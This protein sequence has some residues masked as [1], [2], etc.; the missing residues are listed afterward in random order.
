MNWK[1]YGSYLVL[2]SNAGLIPQF[3]GGTEEDREKSESVLPPRISLS[4]CRK[5]LKYYLNLPTTTSFHILS[6]S[7]SSK[8]SCR[9]IYI[10]YMLTALSNRPLTGLYEEF[11]KQKV[12]TKL[13]FPQNA[14]LLDGHRLFTQCASQLLLPRNYFN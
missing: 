8:S 1:L 3:S 14:L 7:L 10:T 6:N 2:L 13:Q 9:S 4:S 12:V 5:M 11:K